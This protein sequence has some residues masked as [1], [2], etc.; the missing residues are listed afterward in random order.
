M[1]LILSSNKMNTNELQCENKL[2]K[3]EAVNKRKPHTH[4]GHVVWEKN[5]PNTVEWKSREKPLGKLTVF[6]RG[7]KHK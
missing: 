5:I 1:Q 2:I 4:T 3:Q 6:L 7:N